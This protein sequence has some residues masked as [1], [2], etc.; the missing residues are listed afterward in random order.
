MSFR[1]TRRRCIGRL[2]DPPW[3]PGKANRQGLLGKTG[4]PDMVW[5][6]CKWSTSLM[7]VRMTQIRYVHDADDALRTWCGWCGWCVTRIGGWADDAL[8]STQAIVLELQDDE[9]LSRPFR[10]LPPSTHVVWKTHHRS[11]TTLLADSLSLPPSLPL[12]LCGLATILTYCFDTA[13]G[14]DLAPSRSWD[15]SRPVPM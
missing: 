6:W 4:W 1:L 2:W 9:L 14:Q 5:W 13:D 12:C 7:M 15:Q 3:S 8:R 11:T 10:Q